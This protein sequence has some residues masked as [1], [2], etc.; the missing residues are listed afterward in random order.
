MTSEFDELWS[1]YIT[2]AAMAAPMLVDALA[3]M[4]GYESDMERM[5]S[6][7]RSWRVA[8]GAG[9]HDMDRH[10]R[11]YVLIHLCMHMITNQFNRMDTMNREMNDDSMLAMSMETDPSIDAIYGVVRPSAW[12]KTA[13]DNGLPAH[14]SMEEYITMMDGD[15]HGSG[16]ESQ[17]SSDSESDDNAD[18]SSHNNPNDSPSDAMWS[19]GGSHSLERPPDDVSAEADMMGVGKPS[20]S[21][22][23]SAMKA[24]ESKAESYGRGSGDGDLSSLISRFIRPPSMNWR[25]VLASLVSRT[26]NRVSYQSLE[27]TFTRPNIRAAAFMDDVIMPGLVSY[28]PVIMMALDT[29]GSMMGDRMTKALAEVEGIVRSTS[30]ACEFNMFCV[31]SDMKRVQMVSHVSDLDITGGGGTDMAPAFRY[32]SELRGTHRPDLFILATDGFIPWENCRKWMSAV[33]CDI[34]ILIV[35][36]KGVSGVPEWVGNHARILDISA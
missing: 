24:T 10:E 25:R 29:S 18:G 21:A 33:K 17:T 35:D 16:N 1:A 20:S 26:K 27:R 4:T 13:K 31:D 15:V 8:I 3:M 14:R 23:I 6:I 12:Y 22:I 32:V 5:A 7:D 30:G 36:G 19:D 9:F 34:I 2:S 11:D 28:E